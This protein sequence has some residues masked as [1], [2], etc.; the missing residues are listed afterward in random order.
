MEHRK[1]GGSDSLI[2]CIKDVIEGHT[3]FISASVGV[4]FPF[5]DGDTVETLI[6]N[7]DAGMYCEKKAGNT[8]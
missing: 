4:S 6:K 2:E 3:L 7:A 5:L 8:S 1:Q